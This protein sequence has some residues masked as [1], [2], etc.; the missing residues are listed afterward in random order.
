MMGLLALSL[1][2]TPMT[3]AAQSLPSGWASADIGSPQLSGSASYT[4]STYSVTGA[5]VDIWNN[6]DQFR[7]AY[8]Q[9]TGDG[10]IVA[11]VATLQQAHVWSK[12]GVMI[13]ESLSAGS[14]HAFAVVSSAKG[15]SFQR[16]LATSGVSYS[17]TGL[18]GAAPRWVRLERKGS[19]FT[20]SVSTDGA[21][22]PAPTRS[23]W[24]RRSTSASR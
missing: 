8:R 14:K 5:G 4:G 12:A 6:S 2:L 7:F 13:R 15:L 16:R 24:G 3:A 10:V 18:S 11:R 17:N 1:W 19:T 22:W 9:L 21:S 20:A 23:R